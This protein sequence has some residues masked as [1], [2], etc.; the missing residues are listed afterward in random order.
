MI[1]LDPGADLFPLIAAVLAAGSCA[2]LGN[3]LVLRRL[4]L[5]GDAISHS[6]LPGL[7]AAFLVTGSRAS[8]PML[9]GAAAAGLL[10]VVLVGAVRRLTRVEPGAAMGVVFTILF[11][12]GVLMLAYVP[13]EIDLDTDCLLHGQLE[14]LY[15]HDAPASWGE[16]LSPA[17]IAAA[18]RQVVTLLVTAVAVGVLVGAFYKE[19]RIAAF[20]PSHATA[21]GVPAGLLHALLM[22]A[23]AATTVACF[24]AVGSILVI[25]MLIVPAATARLMTD[26]LGSQIA[27]SL[28]VGIAAAI[29]GYLASFQLPGVFDAQPVNAAGSITVVLGISLTL[30]LVAGPKH[31][32]IARMRRRRSIAKTITSD[33]L[34]GLLYRAEEAGEPGVRFADLRAI[35]RLTAAVVPADRAGLVTHKDDRVSLTEHGRRQAASLIRRHRLWEHYLVE[36]VGLAPDHVH[37]QAEKLE[38]IHARPDGDTPQ[39]PHGRR[40]PPAPR[41]NH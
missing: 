30:T 9:F 32:V 3:Y 5:M 17:A 27:V 28:L 14:A 29:T 38:H 13:H 8:M 18:P 36:H 24:E 11:A 25:A 2:L 23:V 40:I 10:T 33:D 22:I 26:R 16:A 31:S 7:V 1:A 34:L 21:L 12:L 6:V 35:P 15:W 41:G 20:D 4:S 37:D 19:L 39:D